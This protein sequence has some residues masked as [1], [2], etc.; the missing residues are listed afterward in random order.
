MKCENNI[1]SYNIRGCN[2][3]DI[4][5]RALKSQLDSKRTSEWGWVGL[6]ELQGLHMAV[7]AIQAAQQHDDGASNVA[8]KSR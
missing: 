1:Q 8:S 6:I 4:Y 3:D 7:V 5:L 2:T